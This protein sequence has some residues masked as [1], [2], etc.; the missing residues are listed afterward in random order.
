MKN[1]Y[2]VVMAV[3]F[4]LSCASICNAQ[5]MKDKVIGTW[6]LVA[7][8]DPNPGASDDRETKNPKG[9]I[10][11]DATGHM[12][13]QIDRR[14]DRPKFKAGNRNKGTPEELQAAFAHY[15]AYFGTYTINEKDATIT[16]HLEASIYPNEIGRDNLRY[17]DV[18]GNRLIYTVP[19]MKAGKRLPKSESFRKLIWEKVN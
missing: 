16:H 9:Y 3:L 12:T 17:Y 2:P 6:K 7:Y 14:D 19:A 5:S 1:R 4:G 10:T 15:T 13:A 8:V 11:Y 18:E